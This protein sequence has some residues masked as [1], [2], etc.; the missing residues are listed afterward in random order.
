VRLRRSR[1]SAPAV[2]GRAVW[3]IVCFYT[4]RAYRRQGVTR[5][6]IQ[7]AVKHTAVQGAGAVE[8][9]PIAHWGE[10]M[11]TGHAYSGTA[12]T[13]RE[14][15]FYEVGVSGRARGEAR[16]IMRFDLA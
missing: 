15:G 6:L 4:Q 13:F 8:A 11:L 10:T 16:V 1:V 2:D 7:A 3:L 9:F 12:S 5:A 14:L